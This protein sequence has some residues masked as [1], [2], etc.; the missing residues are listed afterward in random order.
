ML[1]AGPLDVFEQADWGWSPAVLFLGHNASRMVLA[2]YPL[3]KFGLTQT[4]AELLEPLVGYMCPVGTAVLED[5]LVDIELYIS[6]A[7]KPNR[8]R[9][10]LCG[11]PDGLPNIALKDGDLSA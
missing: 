11:F 7:E 1:Y 6:S 9:L 4:G 10:V 8:K 2:E 3:G 5:E